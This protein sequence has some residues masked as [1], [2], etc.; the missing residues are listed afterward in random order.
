MTF[1]IFV[2]FTKTFIDK[3]KYTNITFKTCQ[4]AWWL[5]FQ[6]INLKVLLCVILSEYIHRQKQ[7]LQHNFN[8]K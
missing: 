8:F 1:V 4:L 2:Y 6:N 7:I 5:C 3:N